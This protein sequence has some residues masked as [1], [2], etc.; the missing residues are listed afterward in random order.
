MTGFSTVC[1]AVGVI[2]DGHSHSS[3]ESDCNGQVFSG[4]AGFAEHGFPNGGRG[5][6]SD[7]TVMVILPRRWYNDENEEV[8][9]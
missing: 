5:L 3:K 2:A 8:R 9:L 4:I 1:M 7:E 6:S